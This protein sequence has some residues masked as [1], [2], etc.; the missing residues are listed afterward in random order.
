MEYKLWDIEAGHCI[1]KYADED[2]ALATVGSLV[3]EYGDG[4]TESLSLGRVA[5]DGSLLTPLTG[6]ELRA[7]AFEAAERKKLAGAIRRP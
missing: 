2:T 3:A 4:Y 1:G 7:R 6:E 5:E